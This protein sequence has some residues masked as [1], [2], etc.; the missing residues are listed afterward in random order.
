MFQGIGKFVTKELIALAPS[1]T[2]WLHSANNSSWIEESILSSL[3]TLQQVWI[4]KAK[5][6]NP[7]SWPEGGR[8]DSRAT[9]QVAEL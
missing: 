9:R 2:Q 3:S 5:Y 6:V 7:V 4:S 1:T 8:S